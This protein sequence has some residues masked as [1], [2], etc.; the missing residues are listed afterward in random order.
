MPHLDE[1]Y[2]S[3]PSH[4][5]AMENPEWVNKLLELMEEAEQ[6]KLKTLSPT[7]RFTDG[8]LSLSAF[9]HR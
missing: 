1:I 8:E 2:K 9:F 6:E 5:T 7:K 4:T 3:S